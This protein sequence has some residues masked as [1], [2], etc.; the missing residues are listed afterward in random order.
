[1]SITTVIT[2]SA[3]GIG[4][5]T[6]KALEA[7]G[8]SVTGVDLHDAEII[9]DL[10]T[11]AGRAKAVEDILAHCGGTLDA[12]V[13][14]AGLGPHVPKP[15]LVAQVNYF[16]AVALLDGLLPA[17]EKGDKPAA[18]VI[19]SVASTQLAWDKNPLA[20]AFEAGDEEKIAGVLGASGEQAGYLAYAASKNA[21]TV[22]LRKRTAAWGKAGVRL[23]A[24]APGATQT[25][26]LEAGLEDP[27]YGDAIRDFVPP[28]GRRAEPSEMAS[29]VSFLLS[30]QASYLHGAQ[31][32]VDGGIDAV[33]RPT[34]F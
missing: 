13:L 21:L 6:R 17:L 30:Q 16:G 26:L 33:T 15:M 14:C 28:I 9:A 22:A 8:Y 2:G 18:V 5:A 1:M 20:A 29:V 31:L 27:R 10:S 4:A 24:V 3:S 32:V 25:P 23:N 34:Q 7:S 12:L 11:Q 19:S